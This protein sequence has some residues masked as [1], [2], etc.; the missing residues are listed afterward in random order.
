MVMC[1]D[2]EFPELEKALLKPE[3]QKKNT[4]LETVEEK[5]VIV[6]T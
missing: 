5:P 3:R 1:F 2:Y 4:K 6:T